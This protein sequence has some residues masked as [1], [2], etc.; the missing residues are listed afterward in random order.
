MSESERPVSRSVGAFGIVV[1]SCGECETGYRD[2]GGGGGR[3]G[4]V[5]DGGGGGR[6]S[7]LDSP[8]MLCGTAKVEKAL[9]TRHGGTFDGPEYASDSSTGGHIHGGSRPP[10]RWGLTSRGTLRLFMPGGGSVK[11]SY[12]GRRSDEKYA[13]G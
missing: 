1:V 2:V 4:G 9:G 13:L 10:A 3:G 8:A 7:K 11:P 5:D 6:A 12:T